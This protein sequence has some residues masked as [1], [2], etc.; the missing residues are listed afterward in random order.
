MKFQE[1]KTYSQ[2]EIEKY[3]LKEM[4]EHI[5]KEFKKTAPPL[6][7]MYDAWYGNEEWRE[8]PPM[9]PH[10]IY[11][12]AGMPHICPICGEDNRWVAGGHSRAPVFVCIHEAIHAGR[13]PIRPVSTVRPNEVGQYKILSLED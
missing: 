7:L 6:E 9:T 3:L 1:E 5:L 8:G 2:E 10:K 12:K 13:G 11:D 4:D